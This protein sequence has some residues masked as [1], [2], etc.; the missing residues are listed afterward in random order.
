MNPDSDH[1]LCLHHLAFI[2]SMKEHLLLLPSKIVKLK[3]SVLFALISSLFKSPVKKCIAHLN[4]HIESAL[5]KC[6]VIIINVLI[7]HIWWS[8]CY[9]KLPLGQLG[10][11][12]VCKMTVLIQLQDQEIFGSFFGR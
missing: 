10:V 4:I 1:P 6:I 3:D 8:K 7:I 9:F 5:Y 11:S 12:V 2:L